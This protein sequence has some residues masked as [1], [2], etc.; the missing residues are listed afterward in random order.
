MCIKIKQIM[1]GLCLK[2]LKHSVPKQLIYLKTYISAKRKPKHF[3]HSDKPSICMENRF[4]QDIR[5][6][7][8]RR[9]LRVRANLF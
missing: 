1:E 7:I 6:M 3:Y 9:C 8:F 5:L 4:L 2:L